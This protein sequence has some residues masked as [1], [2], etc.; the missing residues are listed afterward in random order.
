MPVQRIPRYELLLKTLIGYTPEDH[1][2]FQNLTQALVM[3][4]KPSI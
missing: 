2:D 3:V 4:E 1:V